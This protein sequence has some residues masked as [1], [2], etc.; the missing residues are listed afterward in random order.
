MPGWLLS[1]P[2]THRGVGAIFVPLPYLFP[3][4]GV[5]LPC[6]SMLLVPSVSSQPESILLSEA[7]ATSQVPPSHSLAYLHFILL[8]AVFFICSLFLS[9]LHHS[10]GMYTLQ[11]QKFCLSCS[12]L[13]TSPTLGILPVTS[14]DHHKYL[15]DQQQ[16]YCSITNV[17]IC[18]TRNSIYTET[19]SE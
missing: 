17:P 7:L 18:I 3:F 13:P 14:S 1:I 9:P 8:A 12:R 6:C 5:F 16:I 2:E 10:L 19:L 4:P 15:L 11:E